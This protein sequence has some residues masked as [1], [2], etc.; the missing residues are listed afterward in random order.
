MTR[1]RHVLTA[2]AA[3]TLVAPAS[4]QTKF[5]SLFDGTSLAGWTTAGEAAWSVADGMVS[6]DAGPM[7]F[8]V[9]NGSYRDFELRVEFWVSDDAN[10]G[11]FIR[12]A[13]RTEISA[14][15]CY[16]VNIYDTRPDPTYGTGAIVDV[17]AVSPMPKAGGRWN[18]M[19]ITARNDRFSVTLN[20]RRTVEAARDAAHREGPFALQRAAG[21]VRFRKVELRPL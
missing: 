21:T 15:A 2:L 12:C 14:T 18:T 8:L 17:A 7:T 9:S 6:A 16:E 11:V 10:S 19:I 5:E 4:A 13:S 3:V 1:G 20:G